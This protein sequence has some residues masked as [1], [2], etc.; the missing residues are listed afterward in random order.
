MTH[1][2]QIDLENDTLAPNS[3]AY[4]SPTVIPKTPPR[5]NKTSKRDLLPQF[6]QEVEQEDLGNDY[7]QWMVSE[8]LVRRYR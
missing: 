5:P 1:Q 7:P 3:S 6:T 8:G 2:T 4:N